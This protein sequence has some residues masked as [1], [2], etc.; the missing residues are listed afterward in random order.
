MNSICTDIKSDATET[1]VGKILKEARQKHKIRD[2]NVIAEELCIKPY[3]LE[4]LEQGNFTSFPSSCYA[5]GFLKNYASF[6][7]LNNEDIVS[8]YEAEYAGSK[9]CVVLS[10]P[11]AKK[12]TKIPVKEMAGIATLCIAIV[13]IWTGFDKLGGGETIDNAVPTNLHSEV[14]APVSGAPETVTVESKAATV[15]PKAI[16]VATDQVRLQAIEDVWVRLSE[17]DGSVRVEKILDKGQDLVV[18]ADEGLSLMTNNAAALTVLITGREAKPLGAHGQIIDNI[19][20]EQQ[21]LVELS[22]LD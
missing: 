18:P 19:K 12:Y 4:A 15:E 8:R 7:G 5:T 16:T 9:E 13:G 20:L 1:N 10:F 11:E 3:L 22:L 6:L 17:N 14:T 21:E 2:L